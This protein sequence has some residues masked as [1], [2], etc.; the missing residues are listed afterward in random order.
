MTKT[1]MTRA[2]AIKSLKETKEISSGVIAA[3]GMSMDQWLRYC[4]VDAQ[5]QKRVVEA[6]L[7]REAA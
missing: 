6:I 7:A 2:V 3:L 1:K 5:T 4:Q